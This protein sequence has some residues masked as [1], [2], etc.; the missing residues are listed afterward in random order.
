MEEIIRRGGVTAPEPE[1]EP[2]PQVSE[3]VTPRTVLDWLKSIKLQVCHDALA[4]QCTELP[5]MRT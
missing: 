2:E 3:G 5:T 1:P 4:E